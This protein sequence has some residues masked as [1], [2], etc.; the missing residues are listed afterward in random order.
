MLLKQLHNLKVGYL[1]AMKISTLPPHIL[2]LHT[3]PLIRIFRVISGIS[4]L[5]VI[6][7]RYK[8]ITNDLQLRYYIVLCCF[9]I[10]VL[11][12]FYTTFISYHKII[13]IRKILK[14]TELDIYDSPLSIIYN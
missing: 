5:F 7:G 11:F 3:H 9:I 2:K 14:G 13:H 6:T 8:A 1:R 12:L 10:S 4:I